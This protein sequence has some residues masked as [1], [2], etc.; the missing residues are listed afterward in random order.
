MKLTAR[1]KKYL[2]DS[3]AC[4]ATASDEEFR[5][6][7]AK[8][9]AEGSLD[10]EKLVELTTTKEAEE[11]SEFSKVMKGLGDA[12]GELKTILLEEKR[13]PSKE[14]EE[15]EGEDE[16]A[17]KAAKHEKLKQ[18]FISELGLSEEAAEKAANTTLNSQK[19]SAGYPK[20]QEVNEGEEMDETT[21]K[22]KKGAKVPGTK[23]AS[24][25]EKMVTRLGGLSGDDDEVKDFDVRIKDAAAG[26]DNTKSAMTYPTQTER[27]RPHPLAG[28]SV[29]DFS[30]PGAGRP[31]MNPS[32]LDKAVAG[33]W[34]K[35]LVNSTIKRSRTLGF[36]TLP[37]HDKGLLLHA[38]QKM[39]WGGATDGGD[40]ADIK[41]RRLTPHEQ[42][43]VIDDTTSGG[44]FAAPIVFDDLVIQT[45]LLNGELYPLVN[46]IPLDRG[47]RVEG[48]ATLNVTA[49]WG[50]VDDTAIALFNTAAYITAFDTTVF[51]WE[52]AIRVGL[53]F[54]SDTPVDFGQ[55]LTFQ[56][57]ERLLADLDNVI[58]AGN[59][60]TQPEGVT[61][62]SGVT[63][64]NFGGS[65]TIG[66]YESLRFAV[67][68]QEH[69][70]N[71]MSTAV[72]C[73]NETSYQR[74][75][76]IPVGAS[77][78]RRL[79]NTISLPNYDG[80]VWM[81]RP[82]KINNSL[83]NTTIFYAILGRYR[84]YRRRGLTMRT[85]T[86]G[87]TLIRANEMLLVGTAR[88]G[89]QIERSAVAS[90]TTTAPA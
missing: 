33:A 28:K 84:M 72:F 67:A 14:E 32:E 3:E 5:V 90:L 38:L 61:V 24:T 88:Y 44:L 59:G 62:H 40:F 25:L 26:Y 80:Y 39:D 31:M 81:N 64:V 22:P 75:M 43:A 69:K 36:M 1:L 89:G 65:T 8:A 7:A 79:T 12:V 50:G 66:N 27:G 23:T 29:M 4:K 10:M 46:T 54:L 71:L 35:F 74:A 45:P 48:I 82:Y 13:K 34:G 20:V 15:A 9:I 6:A 11:A 77:D 76:A 85:S 78:A 49:N 83:A 73:G 63:S 70:A 16:E 51:R 42:K 55:L 87:D 58:A 21:G 41:G 56:Y 53:D 18:Y 60:S 47:R 17:K 30:E 68:K 2:V 19:P 52:G 86:E 57:G 37:E